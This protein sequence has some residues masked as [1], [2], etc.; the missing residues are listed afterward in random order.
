MASVGGGGLLCGIYQGLER[1]GWSDV[2]VI[3]TETEGAASFYE[4][5]RAGKLVRLDKIDTLA[6]SLGALEVT[7]AALQ[8]SRKQPTVPLVRAFIPMFTKQAT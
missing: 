7:E 2:T 1:H 4:A 3:A 6:T 5:F 8:Y